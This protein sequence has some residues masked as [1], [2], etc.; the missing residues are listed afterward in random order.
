MGWSVLSPILMLFVMKVVFTQ[1]FG[2]NTPHYTTYLFCGNLVWNYFRESTSGGMSSLMANKGIITKVNIPKYM[3]LLSKNVSSLINFALTLCVFFIFA[4]IDE[5]PFS[6]RMI[7]LL[8]PIAL[9]VIY[10]IGCGLILSALFVFF[11]DISYLYD[12]L[13]MLQMYMSAI[14]YRIDSYPIEIQ[15]LFYL[16]PVYC[17]IEYF[18]TVVIDGMIPSVSLH[19]MCAG[20]ALLFLAIGSLVYKKNNQKF[21][22]YM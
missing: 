12:I 7:T 10:N 9:L 21:L 11:R 14:F 2:R 6:F 1:F 22:Y 17:F 3:F 13:T 18:R 5:I 8:Y 19:A 15:K 16:N 20:Y 4:A